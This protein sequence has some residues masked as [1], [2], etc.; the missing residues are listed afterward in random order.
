MTGGRPL[1]GDSM[2][3]FGGWKVTFLIGLLGMFVAGWAVQPVIDP[4]TWWHLRVGEYVVDKSSLPQTDFISRV[5]SQEAKPWVAYSW[6]YEI[7][8]FL[9]FDALGLYGIV[10][11]RLVSVL[12]VTAVVMRL[13]FSHA[14]EAAIPLAVAAAWVFGFLPFCTERPWHSSVLLC[15]LTLH[16]LGRMTQGVSASS[17]LW[18]PPMFALAANLHIQFVL[19]LGLLGIGCVC[20]LAVR[21]IDRRGVV[22]MTLACFGFTLINP[23]FYDI[24]G[25]VYE[26]ASHRVPAEIIQELRPPNIAE[27]WNWP[28]IALSVFAAY[29]LWLRGMPVMDTLIFL[30]GLAFAVRSQRDTWFGLM[31]AGFVAVR[32]TFL[33]QH[34]AHQTDLEIDISE[35]RIR[36]ARPALALLPAFGFV[37][38]ASCLL[39]PPREHRRA[40][41]LP[42]R[43]GPLRQGEGPPRAVVQHARLGRL[44]LVEPHR[45]ARSPSTAARTSTATSGSPFQR[46]SGTAKRIPKVTRS[47]AAPPS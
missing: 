36:P 20:A 11:L 34:T 32:P 8:V 42:R 26:Y 45:P 14:E 35:G 7:G 29:R 41:P 6:L 28:W 19:S 43:G 23:Y 44:A 46:A 4:D 38:V 21:T 39:L 13:F 30:A 40:G 33:R 47:S 5:G 37:S 27:W 10:L 12:V 25:V 15:A 9:S 3:D 18:L 22:L 1:K 16:V 17:F 24:Y 31:T 2:R